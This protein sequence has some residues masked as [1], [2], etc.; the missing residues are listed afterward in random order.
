[1]I[2]TILNLGND[3][4]CCLHYMVFTDL[5]D[6]MSKP[7]L[8]LL[9]A[10]EKKIL[11]D[12]TVNEIRV[13]FRIDEAFNILNILDKIKKITTETNFIFTINFFS[14]EQSF[15]DRKL[16]YYLEDLKYTLIPF[17]G[18][19]ELDPSDNNPICVYVTFKVKEKA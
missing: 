17:N 5:T 9:A 11:I 3:A 10:R 6:T 16:D 19:L 2:P 12:E 18:K 13:S 8:E 7:N 15:P 4:M 1:M 14:S